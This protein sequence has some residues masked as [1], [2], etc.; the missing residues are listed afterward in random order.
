MAN[1]LYGNVYYHSHFAGVLRQEPGERTSFTYH[2]SYLAAGQPAI[3]HTLP[4]QREPVVAEAGL[5]PFFDNLVAEGWL[6][7]AQTRVLGKRRASRFELLLAFGHDCAGAVSVIDPDPQER[8]PVQPDHPLDLAV[9][10]GR[11]SLSGIQPKLAL[12][13]EHGSFRPTRARELSTHLGKFP[14]PRHEDLTANEYLTT[15]ALKALLPDDQIVEMHLGRVEGVP[16]QALIIPRFDRTADGRRIH[17]EEF[18]QLLGV[19]SAH[20]YDGS[21]RSLADFIRETPG[22]LPAETY[23]LYRR[24]LAGLLLGNTDM[25]LK[26]FA[27]IHT[28][29]GLRLSPAYDALAAALY[30]YTTLAL[31]IGGTANLPLGRLK[32]Q[33]LIRLGQDFGLSLA[34]IAMATAHLA[35]R[36]PAA[37]EAVG[38]SPVGTTA[39]KEEILTQMER[40]WNGTFALIGPALSKKRSG[41]AKPNN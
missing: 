41:G 27:M 39:L 31:S 38:T 14:S 7:D 4:L 15:R 11:A 21:Y 23:R 10:A 5:P 30:G 3:A 17:F 22:C 25:H 36:R 8:G 1:L 24:I 40:R 26:N 16:E 18:T 33:T 32:A 12:I 19:P 9:L 29:A 34:A 2:E 13:H 28:E 37:T 35:R 6:E 20:K